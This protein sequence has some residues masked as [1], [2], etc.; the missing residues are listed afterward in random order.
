MTA[1]PWRPVRLE[2]FSAS[3]NDMLIKYNISQDLKSIQGTIELEVEGS[4]DKADVCI[5]LKAG[6]VFT[7]SVARSRESR[8]VVPFHIGTYFPAQAHLRS[9][10]D[11]GR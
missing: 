1:G 7:T 8:L 5:S 10:D 2:V 3:I 9:I 4:F 11:H 6:S